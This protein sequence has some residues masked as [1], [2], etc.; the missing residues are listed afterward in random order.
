MPSQGSS[1]VPLDKPRKKMD[2]FL[3]VTEFRSGKWMPKKVA[4]DPVSAGVVY[5][6]DFDKSPY[7]IIPVDHTWL[8]DGPFLLDVYNVNSS[9]AGRL[10][11]LAGCKG[12][13]EPYQGNL[14]LL[15]V[16]TRFQRDKLSYI[17]NVEDASGD[18]LVPTKASRSRRRSSTRHRA[19]FVS[20][21]RNTCRFLTRSISWS[22]PP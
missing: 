9:S 20:P 15:P 19:Y 22:W 4:Q 16:L 13:P 5:Q 7:I 14:P 11:E 10:F 3:A 6:G 18:P 2:V 12:Y 17:K 8:P 21:T 1:N